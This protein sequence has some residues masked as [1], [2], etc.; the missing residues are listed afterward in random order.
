[1]GAI[2][3]QITSLTIVYS[4]VNSDADQRKHQSSVSL[5]FVWVIQW[6]PVNFPHK[7]PVTR[8]VF[9]LDDFIMLPTGGFCTLRPE[10]NGYGLER[11][12]FKLMFSKENF[13]FLFHWSL[14]QRFQFTLCQLWFRLWP[15]AK[16]TSLPCKWNHVNLNK[17]I[18]CQMWCSMKLDFIIW[19]FFVALFI[20]TIYAVDIIISIY[21]I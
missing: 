16:E 19:T 6:G 1:M 13:N 5:A 14:F 10:Q 20:P 18:V 21:A 8:K 4:T 15:G 9:P 11:D 3:S 17:I 7:W 2:A 12:F